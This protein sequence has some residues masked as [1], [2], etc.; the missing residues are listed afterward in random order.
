MISLRDIALPRP[1]RSGGQQADRSAMATPAALWEENQHL[2][3][4][5]NQLVGEQHRIK[6][7]LAEFIYQNQLEQ[8]YLASKIRI[9]NAQLTEFTNALVATKHRVPSISDNSDIQLDENGD[10]KAASRERLIEA[11]FDTVQDRKDYISMFLL[12]YR[13]FATTNE[14]ITECL[15]HYNRVAPSV[16]TANCLA[17][18]KAVNFL[19]KWVESFFDDFTENEEALGK[20]S[21]LIEAMSMTDTRLGPPFR[22]A[23]ALK[24]TFDK[25]NT[26]HKA[27][28]EVK[29]MVASENTP[30]FSERP[31][32]SIP[33]KVANPQSVLDLD[34][35][36]VAR[37]LTLIDYE[38]CRAI[39]PKECLGLAWTKKDKLKRS[40]NL[41]AMI[42]GFNN[43]SRWVTYTLVT[44]LNL[45]KR[46]KILSFFLSVLQY[47]KN[48]HNNFNAV[49]AIVGGFGNSAVHRLNKTFNALS[50]NKLKILNEQK[51][52][53]DPTKSWAN[54]RRAITEVNPPCVP[55]VGV[56]QT[57]LTFIEEGN[58][59]KFSA[60]GFI[61][62]KKCRMI[63]EVIVLIQQYQQKPYNLLKCQPVTDFLKKE[64]EAATKMEDKQMYERSLQA[65]PRQPQN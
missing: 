6:A 17:H 31:P 28:G 57:D 36:E 52:F 62:F 38:L 56:Y 65:E 18:I 21:R 59:D 1:L 37:Q 5:W 41:L 48:E 22:I 50:E 8:E 40:P 2:Q 23:T 43:V 58:P 14:V 42:Q 47:L 49:F 63:A 12:T 29:T 3:M 20:C 64:F 26:A 55:F 13:Y 45:K 30:S 4:R 35:Q 25:K 34:P 9:V 19:K 27:G 10:I 32:A 44:E 61:N 16:T 24:N 7:R 60:T 11:L 33:P 15:D 54:Y 46:T 51:E 53:C 39:R